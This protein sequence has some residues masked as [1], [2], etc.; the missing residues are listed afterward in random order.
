MM[1]KISLMGPKG[2]ACQSILG[3]VSIFAHC[4]RALHF[5]QPMVL[6]VG[7]V[8]PSLGEDILNCMKHS[9]SL[10]LYWLQKTELTQSSPLLVVYSFIKCLKMLLA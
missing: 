3:S 4:S 10:S 7:E 6:E 9:L 2:S 8:V 5:F 1:V